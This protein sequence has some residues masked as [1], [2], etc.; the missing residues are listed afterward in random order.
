MFIHNHLIKFQDTRSLPTVPGYM[1][2]IIREAV[3]LGLHPNN[4][5][6]EDG[7]TFNG[8]WKPLFRLLGESRRPLSSSDWLTALL[9]VTFSILLP[10]AVTAVPFHNAVL[11][12]DHLLDILPF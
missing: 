5:N 9:K 12:Q 8:S 1:D 6:R 10:Q 4:M 11:L 7:L 2:R 3:E